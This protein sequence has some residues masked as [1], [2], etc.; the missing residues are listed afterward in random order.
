MIHAVA[1]TAQQRPASLRLNSEVIRE[2]MRSQGIPSQ[3][4]LAEEIGVGRATVVRA[5]SGRTSPSGT[6]LAGLR[7]RLDLSLDELA[8]AVPPPARKSA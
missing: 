6:V 2:A 3:E 4:R 7:L 5:L 8:E 1:M